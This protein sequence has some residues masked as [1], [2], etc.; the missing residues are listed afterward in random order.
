MK[1]LEI[2]E[3]IQLI[4]SEKHFEAIAI[5]G[6]FTIKVN[7]YLPY[8]C[9]AIC[10]ILFMF[11]G[12]NERS[13]VQST[14]A[15]YTS[16]LIDGQIGR[17]VGYSLDHRLMGIYSLQMDIWVYR[18]IGSR[19]VYTHWDGIMLGYVLRRLLDTYYSWMVIYLDSGLHAQVE[20][21]IFY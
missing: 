1:R 5:D 19:W 21:G 10:Y 20:M 16:M 12:L 9:S 6:S 11:N 13:L 18:Q 2:K 15:G 3:I 8:C 17:W 4:E 7:K 14:A